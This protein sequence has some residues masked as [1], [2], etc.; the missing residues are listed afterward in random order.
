MKSKQFI[1]GVVVGAVMTGTVGVFGSGQIVSATKTDD[2]NIYVD[3]QKVKDSYGILNYEGRVYTSARLIAEALDADVDYVQSNGEKNIYITSPVVETPVP[4]PTPTPKPTPTP[5]PSVDYR[6]PPVKG[7]ALGTSIYVKSAMNPADELEVKVEVTNY[8]VEGNIL[9]NYGAFKIVDT[10][11]NIYYIKKNYNTTMFLNSIPSKAEDLAETLRFND[12]PAGTKCTLIM[13]V[14]RYNVNGSVE[15]VD[16][17]IP[18]I[19]EAY[20]VTTTH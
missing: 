10:K 17:E 13:P 16:I 12:I 14:S 18:L 11:D 9:F 7:S 20:D 19:I 1:A 5:T 4:T 2:T 3:G 15:T 6:T 8:N